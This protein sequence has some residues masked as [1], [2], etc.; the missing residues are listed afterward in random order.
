[1]RSHGGCTNQLKLF[2][3]ILTQILNT[4]FCRNPTS[5]LDMKHVNGQTDKP[6]VLIMRQFYSFYTKN[7]RPKHL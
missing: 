5:I 1:M 7:H 3:Q 6:S 2:R 4:K